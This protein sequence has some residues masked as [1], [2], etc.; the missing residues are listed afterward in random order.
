MEESNQTT[1]SPKPDRET[2]RVEV[3]TTDNPGGT[4]VELDRD[5]DYVMVMRS[6]G[7]ITVEQA[8]RIRKA[9][10]D[11][12]GREIPV[13]VSEGDVQFLRVP[14]E[15]HIDGFVEFLSRPENEDLKRSFLELHPDK[16]PLFKRVVMPTLPPARETESITK[17]S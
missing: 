4:I 9:M 17:T 1:T 10:S 13:I 16:A 7:D 3:V 8:T 2:I 11:F 15:S 6:H 14:K 5:A 12:W